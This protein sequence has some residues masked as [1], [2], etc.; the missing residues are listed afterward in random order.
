MSPEFFTLPPERAEHLGRTGYLLGRATSVDDERADG[1][2]VWRT[3]R[4]GSSHTVER[5]PTRREESGRLRHEGA[6]ENCC[7]EVIDL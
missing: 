6:L 1:Q 4:T 7:S 5:H 3:S 2:M